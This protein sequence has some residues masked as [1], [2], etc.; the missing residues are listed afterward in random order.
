MLRDLVYMSYQLKSSE[1]SNFETRNK[2]LIL[3]MQAI[4]IKLFLKKMKNHDI[5]KCIR[6]ILLNFYINIDK[7]SKSI[8]GYEISHECGDDKEIC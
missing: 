2:S 1:Q 5:R 7:A 4:E 3:K 6:N 8:G